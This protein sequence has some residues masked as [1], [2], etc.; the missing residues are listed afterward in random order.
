MKNCIQANPNDADEWRLEML[1]KGRDARWR[2]I[3][4]M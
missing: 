1:K 3:D 4:K 2:R